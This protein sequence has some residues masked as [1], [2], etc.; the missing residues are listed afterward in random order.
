[1]ANTA[2]DT[3][4]GREFRLYVGNTASPANDTAYTRVTNENDLTYKVSVAT[5]DVN[6]K[7]NGGQQA[8]LTGSTS[9]EIS[10]EAARVYDDD[11]LPLLVA[12]RGVNWAFQIRYV[13]DGTAEKKFV[14]GT[15]LVTEV[16]H[17]FGAD[18]A[19]TVSL[20]LKGAGNVLEHLDPV[21]LVNA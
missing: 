13:V 19:A 1:M 9:Y 18:G 11:G 20:T 3:K 12:A 14:E 16:E 2:L 10:T 7:E 8:T 4:L 6:M 15:F 17:K 21:A 5:T